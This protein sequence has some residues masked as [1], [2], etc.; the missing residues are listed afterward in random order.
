MGDGEP[1]HCPSCDSA[2]V[3][4]LMSACGFFSKD[5]GGQT[6]KVPAGA[7]GCGGCTAS[8]CAG[9]SH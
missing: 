5:S 8:S 6:V 2:E 7:S 4:R 3:C 9:C 1:D